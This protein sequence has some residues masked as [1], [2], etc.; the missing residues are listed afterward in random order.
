[1]QGHWKNKDA[2]RGSNRHLESALRAVLLQK[3]MLNILVGRR[4]IWGVSVKSHV[5]KMRHHTQ[6]MATC[7]SGE[8][9]AKIWLAVDW[10]TNSFHFEKLKR[11]RQVFH[12]RH[13]CSDFS[14]VCSTATWEAFG[15][16]KKLHMLAGRLY[17]L[18]KEG[19]KSW[20][21]SQPHIRTTYTPV[22]LNDYT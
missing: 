2:V 13:W 17:R 18:K 3:K 1:M 6:P 22:W 10:G 9:L 7:Y 15:L 16:G 14:S 4:G 8:T 5:K 12:P 11:Y 21:M 20:K 19:T